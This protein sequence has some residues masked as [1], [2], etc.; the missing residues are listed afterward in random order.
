MSR[1]GPDPCD[2]PS[3]AVWAWR[4]PGGTLA[5][6]I[7]AP[8]SAGPAEAAPSSVPPVAPRRP[9][10]F[11]DLGLT[12]V[13]HR[14]SGTGTGP[15]GTREN[16]LAAFRWAADLGAP[17]VELDVQASRDAGL[18]VRHDLRDASGYVSAADAVDWTA[19]DLLTLERLHAELPSHVG[20]DVEVK[21]GLPSEDGSDATT[22]AALAFLAVHA[23]ER[24]WLLTSFDPTVV[25][26]AHEHSVPTGWLTEDEASLHGSVAAAIRLRAHA[27]CPH[28]DAVLR[29]HPAEAPAEDVLEVASRFGV[30]VLVWGAVPAQV[31]ALADLG[32]DA[33]C[34]DAVQET[35]QVLGQGPGR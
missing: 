15:A 2:T 33:V 27:V 11:T 12:V 18:V 30:Q 25:V 5:K 1:P 23:R 32:V 28:V 14:G 35:L 3:A 19:Q 20:I 7:M 4:L 21:V 24:P 31:P 16:S 34:V 10:V 6:V 13:A 9:P 22:T 29:N 17:W 26:R 8:S